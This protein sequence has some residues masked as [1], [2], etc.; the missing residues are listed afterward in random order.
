MTKIDS[1]QGEFRW[2]SNFHPCLIVYE[3]RIYPTVENAYQAAKKHPSKRAPFTSVGPGLAKRM[4]RGGPIREDWE[5][6]KVGV[7]TRLI[8]DK[9]TPGSV[10]ALRLVETGFAEIIEG[11]T[12]GDRFWGVCQGEGANHLGRIL[13]ERRLFLAGLT[14]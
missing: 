14:K 2:L 7:M 13:M 8:A 6:V 9:F 3:G 4:G 5:L 11:N 10:L 1:F 12:W